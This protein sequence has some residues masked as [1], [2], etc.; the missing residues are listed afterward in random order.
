MN[1]YK[2][3]LFQLRLNGNWTTPPSLQHPD[4]RDWTNEQVI[5]WI[6]FMSSGGP[7]PRRAENAIR[8]IRVE[9]LA[10]DAAMH[11]ELIISGVR[12][13]PQ[14]MPIGSQIIPARRS[15]QPPEQLA[16]IRPSDEELDCGVR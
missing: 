12:V 1:T 8:A 14:Q 11:D 13:V 3:T 15:P 9:V 4:S 16:P 7:S 6:D 5:E 2:Q 10:N